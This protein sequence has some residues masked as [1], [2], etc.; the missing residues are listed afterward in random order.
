MAKGPSDFQ[1]DRRYASEMGRKGGKAP[2]DSKKPKPQ[3]KPPAK[4]DAAAK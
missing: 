2:R 1:L 3:R 4:P